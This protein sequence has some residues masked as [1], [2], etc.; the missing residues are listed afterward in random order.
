[1]SPHGQ[2]CLFV[3]RYLTSTS[4]AGAAGVTEASSHYTAGAFY[5]FKFILGKISQGFLVKR[6]FGF[7]VHVSLLLT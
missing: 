2:A 5:I 1:V 7:L 4:E 6:E 3:F